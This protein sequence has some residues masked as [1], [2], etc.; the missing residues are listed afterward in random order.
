[1][2][3]S[4][5]AI[6]YLICIYRSLSEFDTG[7]NGNMR[8]STT[9]VLAGALAFTITSIALGSEHN[10]PVELQQFD[11]YAEHLEPELCDDAID[12]D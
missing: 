3:H 12:L 5:G 1:M 10:P 6:R 7:G 4:F 2:P 9:T 8:L 11:P